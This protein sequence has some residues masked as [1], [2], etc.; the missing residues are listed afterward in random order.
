[1]IKKLV[2]A[3]NN[4]HKL[5]E[6]RQ[7]LSP[8]GIEVLFQ[9]EAGCNV[10]PEENG[11]T[12][13]EN[14]AIKAKAVY[15]I[16]KTAVIADD[17]GI[18]VDALDGKPGVK[19]ARFAPSGKECEALLN[20]L[21]SV[22][23][24]NRGAKFVSVIAF[25]DE[26]GQTAIVRGECKGEIGFEI[27]GENGFG[28][29]PIFLPVEFGGEKSFAEVSEQEKNKISHRAVALQKLYNLLNDGGSG[30]DQ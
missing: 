20:A 15:S 6:V 18:C 24:G 28:Y 26:N 9:Q 17:S 3:T 14:A 23:K 1:M 11:S 7:V 21:N 12:F 27:K 4:A 25:I 10:E 19:S 8:L 13:E 5:R 22:E 16:V 2:L 30:N 29:D